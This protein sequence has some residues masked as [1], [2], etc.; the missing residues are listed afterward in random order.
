MR[1]L[2]IDSSS[3]PAS[4]AVA[5]NG[6]II[7][8]F[9]ININRTHSEKLL[10]MTDSLLDTLGLK[11]SDMDAFAISRGP[12]SF[13]GLRIGMSAVKL[14]A[15][16]SAKPLIAVDTLEAMAAN[17]ALDDGIICPMID[18]RN[19]TVFTALYSFSGGELKEIMAADAVKVEEIA[20]KLV[21]YG[22]KVTVTGE[23]AKYKDIIDNT[24]SGRKALVFA[25][26]YMATQRAGTVALIADKK[27]ASGVRTAPSDVVPFYVRESQAE[28]A[29]RK[30][31]SR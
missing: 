23:Y 3:A 11:V 24:V 26:Q 10:P 17:V 12:G 15:E 4:A 2:A 14:M 8:E 29:K 1:I 6:K 25:P 22:E 19:N 18:A 28:Q 31:E 7:G 27:Y 5:E 16:V 13:T 21:L 30:K 20:E 9:T